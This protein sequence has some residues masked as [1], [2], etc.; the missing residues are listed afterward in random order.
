MTVKKFFAELI[1]TF[2]LVFFGCG[3]AIATAATSTPSGL[4]ACSAPDA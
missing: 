2:A 4:W 1:G 3:V